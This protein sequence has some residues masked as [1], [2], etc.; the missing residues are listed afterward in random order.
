MREL[1]LDAQVLPVRVIEHERGLAL[2]LP[3]G[4]VRGAAADRCLLALLSDLQ[5]AQFDKLYN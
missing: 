3:D 1:E 5:R 4:R 2:Y